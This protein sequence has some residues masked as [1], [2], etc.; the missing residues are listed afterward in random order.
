M[1]NFP[2]TIISSQ[3]AR[4]KEKIAEMIERKIS[5]ISALLRDDDYHQLPEK[6]VRRFTIQR[7][8]AASPDGMRGPSTSSEEHPVEGYGWGKGSR[9]YGGD[10]KKEYWRAYPWDDKKMIADVWPDLVK[11]EV[12][13]LKK[14]LEG[15]G[16]LGEDDKIILE[17]AEHFEEDYK[18][19]IA[20]Q[21]LR[22]QQLKNWHAEAMAIGMQSEKGTRWSN[23]RSNNY[24]LNFGYIDILLEKDPPRPWEAANKMSQIQE[25]LKKVYKKSL[26][27]W[28]NERKKE[29]EGQIKESGHEE[30]AP[31]KIQQEVSKGDGTFSE[32]ATRTFKCG[33]GG[34]VQ[35]DKT[36]WKRYQSG[37]TLELTCPCEGCEA[38]GEVRKK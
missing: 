8:H 36:A 20:D 21:T 18:K 25:N 27:E 14:T 11:L 37:E 15:G 13:D 34:F 26:E 35:V 17:K 24:L 19:M 1:E 12:A 2:E 29:H 4:E 16:T 10:W 30:S 33:C 3:A 32:H 31:T 22:K 23:Y 6:S 28:E 7:S 38:K 5:S 9:E